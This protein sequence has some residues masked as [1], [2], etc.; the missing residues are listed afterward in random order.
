[1]NTFKLTLTAVFFFTILSG[2]AMAKELQ[3]SPDAPVQ[4][5]FKVVIP[6]DGLPDGV[7]SQNSNN[8]LDVVRHNGRVFLAFRTGPTHF[9]SANVEMYIV[10][11]TDQEHWDFEAKFDRDT[12]LREPRFL[13]FDGRLFM[14]YAVLGTNIMDFEPQGIMITEYQEQGKWTEPEWI[15][16]KGMIPWRT[17]VVNGVPYML[18][19]KGG[20][21][22]YDF[23]EGTHEDLYFLTTRDGKNWTPVVEGKGVAY[24]GGCSETD[25]EFAD[26]GALIAVCRNELG[27]QDGYGSKICRAEPGALA[28]W[29][30]VPDLK[31]YD[32][33]LVFKHGSDIYL[34]GRRNVSKTGY[35]D[36]KKGKD[37]DP[38]AGLNYSIDYWR[39]P[40]R[41]SIWKVDPVEL[42]VSFMDDLPSKGDTCFP[43]VIPM[44]ENEYMLYNYSSPVDGKD[45]SWHEGQQGHT[46]IY[47]ILLTYP[48]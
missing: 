14:Y 15:L 7:V 22:I 12:D 17:K 30:C 47:K 42:K 33:P 24:R 6:S 36:L 5:G 35:F 41:C 27:D 11:S 40:K 44:S 31:K 48:K 2:A 37:T 29:K 34:V 28:D 20:E 43:S 39:R 21:N 26:D 3:K 25:F 10:S 4:S 32:S 1:M 38:K 46:Y 13:A 18:A 45:V 19:Y 8:N 9:A 23:E 16:E